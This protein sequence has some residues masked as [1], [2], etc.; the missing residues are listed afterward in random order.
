MI[1]LLAQL[2]EVEGDKRDKAVKT[3]T[4]TVGEIRKFSEK[5][6]K[7]LNLLI[8]SEEHWFLNTMM[9]LLK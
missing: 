4:T 1:R 6:D 3:F 9:K 2:G 8:Q 5:A 7:A